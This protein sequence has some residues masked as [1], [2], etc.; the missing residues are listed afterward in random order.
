[1][2]FAA[3]QFDIVWENKPANHT[4]VERMLDEVRPRIEPGT[5]V[6]LP[7]LGDTGFSMDLDRIVDDQSLAWAVDLARRRK[8]FLQHGFAR[9]SPVAKG[10][11][12]HVLK[13]R[14][15]AVIISPTGE[16]LADYEKIHPFSYGREA[17]HFTGGD[18]LSIADCGEVKVCPLI[19]YDL[20]F[21]E[22]W[23]A[24]VLTEGDESAEVF[25]IGAS[26]PAAR[27]AHWRALCIARAIE[28]QAYVVAVNR[29]GRDPHVAYAGGSIMV[30][31]RGE[32][33]AEATEKP[34]V[35]QGHVDVQALRAWRT[36]FPAL[37]DARTHLL[38][39]IRAEGATTKPA[40]D[41]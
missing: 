29:C 6:L 19:C 16:M 5:F 15:C 8:I 11:S 2:R 34:Q 31:P 14:N 32:I 25:T 21:P 27:Q 23:R 24:A 35:L 41:R 39:R 33:V 40:S 12:G 7:E 13:G 9:R 38:G 26:W 18:H 37:R 22:L 10:G 20:R 1:M 4:I 17:D 3:V 30:S 36:E 28:N